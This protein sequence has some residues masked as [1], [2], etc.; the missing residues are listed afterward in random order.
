MILDG[1]LTLSPSSP[2]PPP[3]RLRVNPDCVAMCCMLDGV[4]SAAVTAGEE[5]RA[6]KVSH[7]LKDQPWSRQ[8]RSDGVD[9][10]YETI[11]TRS[12]R[13]EGQLVLVS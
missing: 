2:V 9:S 11:A 10:G 1:V 7:R 8:R 12:Y 13:K 4:M 5:S 6:Q 3:P